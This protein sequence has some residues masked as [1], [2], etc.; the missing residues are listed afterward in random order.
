[1]MPLAFLVVVVFAAA[2]PLKGWRRLAADDPAK[3][4]RMESPIARSMH[5]SVFD[6]A[7]DKMW[8][9]G[10]LV[11]WNGQQ[12]CPNDTWSL[13][14][15]TDQWT[16]LSEDQKNLSGRYGHAA[17]FD[18][19]GKQLLLVGG[20]AMIGPT[21]K[22]LGDT[23]ALAV[24]AVKWKR[25]KA[26]GVLPA[27]HG[28]TVTYDPTRRR[29]IVVGGVGGSSTLRGVWMESVWTFN[30]QTQEWREIAVEGKNL[31]PRNFHTT[32]LDPAR[33]RLLVIGGIVGPGSGSAK[34]D[35]WAFDLKT[36]TWQE[37]SPQPLLAARWGHAAALDEEGDR[38]FVVGGA[39]G[40]G[41]PLLA[42]DLWCLDLKQMK[43]EC[44]PVETRLPP[45]NTHSMVWD[46]ARRR[47]VVFGGNKGRYFSG[48][49][50][51]LDVGPASPAASPGLKSE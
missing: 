28:H 23:W 48:E 43:W 46:P 18:P 14:F 10:G 17:A 44:V 25:V 31:P 41:K 7:S 50:W 24:G 32:V 33:D 15:K 19:V 22:F 21:G 9:T 8:I 39:P 35:V 49:V 4:E 40:P 47:L 2:E 36:D 38:L 1:M 45:L 20:E 11:R 29:L 27:R 26:D 34:G 6:P 42:S 12:G 13:D 30:L 5:A 51:V 16:C 3:M 37:A